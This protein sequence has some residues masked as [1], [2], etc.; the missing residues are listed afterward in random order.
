MQGICQ[1]LAALTVG[2]R[3]APPT[4][5]RASCSVAAAAPSSRRGGQLSARSALRGAALVES[6][7]GRALICRA[8]RLQVAAGSLEAGVGLLGNKA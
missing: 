7:A 8:Q 5:A 2:G 4:S 1:S 6:T 3:V